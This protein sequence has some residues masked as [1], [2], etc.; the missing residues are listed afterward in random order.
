MQLVNLHKAI[1]LPTKRCCCK[2]SA[3]EPTMAHLQDG[4]VCGHVIAARGSK[5][6]MEGE[7]RTKPH[8]LHREINYRKVPCFKNHS[9]IR[10]EIGSSAAP[11]VGKLAYPRLQ[12]RVATLASR[13]DQKTTPLKKDLMLLLRQPAQETGSKKVWPCNAKCARA[14]R[15]R[16]A[17]SHVNESDLAIQ[18][19]PALQT[20]LYRTEMRK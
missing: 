19:Q 2:L 20:I 12:T 9:R 7:L 3:A 16:A 11:S 14:A 5:A 6:A 8:L 17:R 10:K 15:S 4:D 1:G 18:E 13:R